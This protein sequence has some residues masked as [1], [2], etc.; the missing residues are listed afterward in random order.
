MGAPSS[1]LPTAVLS[2][3]NWACHMVQ[4][5]V[6]SIQV[7]YI[8]GTPNYPQIVP[9]RH[10]SLPHNA[11]HP[12]STQDGALFAHAPQ[13]VVIGRHSVLEGSGHQGSR[14]PSTVRRQSKVFPRGRVRTPKIERHDGVI[15]FGELLLVGQPAHSRLYL[16]WYARFDVT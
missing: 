3:S 14:R 7:L 12:T 9:P 4:A 15:H 1:V 6:T 8:M 2:G 13:C 16:L 11:R 5:S 10:A